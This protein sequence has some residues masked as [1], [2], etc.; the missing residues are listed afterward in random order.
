[1]LGIYGIGLFTDQQVTFAPVNNAPAPADLILAAEDELQIRIWGQV[2]FSANLRI[3][4]EGD[5]Y[6][7]KV[8]AVHV[9]GLTVAAAQDHLRQAMDRIYRNFELTVDLGQ[10]H[11]IQVY[12]TG[13]GAATGRVHGERAQYPG[14]RC[15]LER[16]ALLFGLHAAYSAQTGGQGPHRLRPL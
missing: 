1:M 3:S 8:G 5:I 7:P 11:S 12:I 14:R 16:R 10:I 9:A 15:V 13:H 2:N 4:R 6:L